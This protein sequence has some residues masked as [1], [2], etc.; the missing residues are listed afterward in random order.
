MLGL[1]LEF[2][3]GRLTNELSAPKKRN[4]NMIIML[5]VKRHYS[6]VIFEF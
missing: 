3:L 6:R 1:I 4:D 2:Q 5:I